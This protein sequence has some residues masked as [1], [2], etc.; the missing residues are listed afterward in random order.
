VNAPRPSNSIPYG[1]GTYRRR[2]FLQRLSPTVVQVDLE[3]DFHRFELKLVHDQKVV[4]TIEAGGER[5]PWSTCPAAAGPLRALEGMELSRTLGSVAKV[6]DPRANCTHM[7]DLAMIAIMHAAA[8]RETRQYDVTCPDW[9]DQRST[10]TLD[11]DGERAL[12]WEIQEHEIVSPA[13]YAG[14]RIAAG[15]FLRWART[16]LDEEDAERAFV[17]WRG[18]MIAWGRIMDLDDTA[19]ASDLLSWT[20]GNCY[21]FS[22][23]IAVDGMRQK[24]S[25]LDFT[26]APGAL[27]ADLEKWSL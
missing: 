12:E 27:L 18:C 8:K 9:Q 14:Q 2:I 16:D 24:E 22:E 20:G 10:V 1:E 3:D 17:L 25:R 13:P 26:D 15:S 23:E 19:R 5:Y 6:A 11:V 21:S 7:F 4:I